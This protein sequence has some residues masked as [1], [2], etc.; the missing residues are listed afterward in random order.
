MSAT[1]K[2]F[3]YSIVKRGADDYQ[4]S[5]FVHIRL[6]SHSID[7]EGPMLSAQLMTD[8]EID[9]QIKALKE[10]LDAVGKRAKAALRAARKHNAETFGARP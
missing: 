3:D 6:G 1:I 9:Y 4:L 8:A 5:P 7:S 2:Q 10:D